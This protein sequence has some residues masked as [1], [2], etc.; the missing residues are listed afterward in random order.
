MYK[1]KI[2][3]IIIEREGVQ[4]ILKYEEGD[5]RAWPIKT[6]IQNLFNKGAKEDELQ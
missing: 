3:E 2:E 5:Q 6:V 4:V 1:R